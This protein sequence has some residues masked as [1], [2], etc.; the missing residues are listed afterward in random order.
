[1]TSSLQSINIV[2]PK[3]SEELMLKYQLMPT[4][5][6]CQIVM[7]PHVSR[8]QL[9]EFV[10]EYAA[11]LTLG[12]VPKTTELLSRLHEHEKKLAAQGGS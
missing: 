7:M 11:E 5:D 10:E 6:N 4:D 8:T 12:K 1:M 2:L 9:R 3:P